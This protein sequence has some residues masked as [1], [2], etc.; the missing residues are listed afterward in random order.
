MAS[1]TVSPPIHGVDF[2]SAPRAAKPITVASGRLS[3]DTFHLDTL[4]E[5]ASL[6]EY[7]AWLRRPGPWLAGFDFP[8]GLPREAVGDLGWPDTWPELTR[9]C[10]SLGRSA[11]RAALDAYRAA[12][13]VGSKFCYRRGDAQAAAHSPLKLVNP[14]VALMFLEGACRLPNANVCVPGMYRGDPR[15]IALEAY[16]G[17]AVR[18][19]LGVRGRVSYKNDALA[20]QTPEHARVRAQIVRRITAVPGL[21]GVRL[22]ADGGLIRQLCADGRGD[23]LDAVLC[24]L[25]AAWAWKRR[26]R[27]YG[28]P[29][30]LDAVEGWIITVPEEGA[31]PRA[32]GWPKDSGNIRER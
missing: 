8:F 19:L 1:R 32:G 18:Q 13:P 9:H 14:P 25:Q 23:L 15:R 10:T 27:N 5:L 24:A 20:K 26:G 28:L 4:H 22:E 29:L 16:P 12:R 6:A 17:Y 11:L 30:D 3:A 21:L 7:E 2:T 31:G